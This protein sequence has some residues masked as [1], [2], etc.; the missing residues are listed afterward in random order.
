MKRW[1]RLSV[2]MV[3]ALLVL[4]AGACDD[5]NDG[6]DA[7]TTTEESAPVDGPGGANPASVHC[8][9]NGG[10]VE[11]RDE[12]EGQAG[13]CVFADGSECE[14]FAFMNGEC[15]PGDNAG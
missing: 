7:T 3:S 12:P 5:G 9:E 15:P 13:Y 8:E 2:L 10:S 11:I 1:A 6:S 4:G 14:E